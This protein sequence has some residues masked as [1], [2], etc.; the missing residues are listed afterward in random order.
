MKLSEDAIIEHYVNNP[1]TAHELLF[2][3]T[4]INLLVFN[5]DIM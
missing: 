4:N 1:I 3:H 2:C 5:V